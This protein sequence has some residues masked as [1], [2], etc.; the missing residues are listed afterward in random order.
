MTFPEPFA[1]V[2]VLDNVTT[3]VT[4]FCPSFVT[5]WVAVAVRIVVFAEIPVPVTISPGVGIMSGEKLVPK[6]EKV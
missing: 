1:I 6:T 2:V 5:D 4:K 3:H